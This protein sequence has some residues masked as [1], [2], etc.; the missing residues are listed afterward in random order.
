MENPGPSMRSKT[1]I[2]TGPKLPGPIT[3][4]EAIQRLKTRLNG[5][6]IRVIEIR[7]MEQ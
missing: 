2:S 1:N 6:R 7:I 5:S 4:D 3:Q